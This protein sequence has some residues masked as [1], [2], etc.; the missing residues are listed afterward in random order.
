ME[1]FF[2]HLMHIIFFLGWDFTSHHREELVEVFD[3][4][5]LLF[6][7]FFFGC[8]GVELVLGEECIHELPVCTIRCLHM[9]DS[10]Q[11]FEETLR[12]E[13]LTLGSDIVEISILDDFFEVGFWFRE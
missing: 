6:V 5:Y 3:V 8:L 1:G 7:A 12:V 4:E 11:L 13:K 9:S 10:P 2:L